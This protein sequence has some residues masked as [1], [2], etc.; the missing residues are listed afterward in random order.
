MTS[1][2]EVVAAAPEVAELAQARIEA[3]GLALLATIRR[4]G[5]PRICGVEPLFARGELWLGM[6]PESR[7]A[8][9]LQRD[10]RLALHN[11]TVDKH[12][13]EGD[14][15]ISGRGVE[16][17][18]EAEKDEMREAFADA[19]DGQPPPPG[20][21]HLFRVDVTEVSTLK[22]AGDHLAM[23]WWRPGGE[24]IHHDRY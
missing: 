8:L 15:R 6:M 14:I 18:D 23:A 24:V 3:T 5:S 13:T 7:K 9:D 4:D 22:P 20:P 19:N 11:A 12:V 21:M 16:I 2:N 17:T 10:P 1:W